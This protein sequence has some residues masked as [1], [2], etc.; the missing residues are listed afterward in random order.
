LPIRTIK[1]KVKGMQ[2]KEKSRATLLLL[3]LMLVGAGVC[4]G[5]TGGDGEFD[6]A[7]NVS[8]NDL[9]KA[10]VRIVLSQ[11]KDASPTVT[12]TGVFLKDVEGNVHL[13][14]CFNGVLMLV[15]QPDPIEKLN[16]S[17]YDSDNNLLLEQADLRIKSYD[18]KRDLISI[19][20]STFKYNGPA[21]AF[22]NDL[23][24]EVRK[25]PAQFRIL[26][27][28]EGNEKLNWEYIFKHQSNTNL[29]DYLTLTRK[30]EAYRPIIPSVEVQVV[31]G[32]ANH[33]MFGVAGGP[34]AVESN[35][36]GK[37]FG[38]VIGGWKTQTWVVPI[39]LSE[40]TLDAQLDD[41]QLA[42]IQKQIDQLQQ[43]DRA[44]LI[45]HYL[46]GTRY[47]DPLFS[48]KGIVVD[49][50]RPFDVIISALSTAS[51]VRE[52]QTKYIYTA[53]N[54]VN[55]QQDT[56]FGKDKLKELKKGDKADKYGD[57]YNTAS[58]NLILGKYHL[59]EYRRN[60]LRTKKAGKL[61]GDLEIVEEYC[62]QLQ[63][64]YNE[65]ETVHLIPQEAKAQKK[66]NLDLTAE[67]TAFFNT[68]RNEVDGKE[69]YELGE[70]AKASQDLKAARYFY[71][72]ALSYQS[73]YEWKALV[74]LAE[75]D[76]VLELKV[77]K[78]YGAISRSK[79]DSALR[80][81]NSVNAL[82]DR[83]SIAEKIAELNVTFEELKKHADEQYK[84]E[85]GGVAISLYKEALRYYPSDA[86]LRTQVQLLDKSDGESRHEKLTT[87]ADRYFDTKDYENAKLRYQEL[88]GMNPNIP[89]ATNRISQINKILED[90]KKQEFTTRAA[91]QFQED[92]L[93]RLKARTGLR[94]LP[95]CKIVYEVTDTSFTMITTYGM[96]YGSLTS[97]PEIAQNYDNFAPG[98][99]TYAG[100]ENFLK[101]Y[102]ESMAES[103]GEMGGKL[104]ASTCS[105]TI[106]GHVDAIKFEED[107]EY[108]EKLFVD[109]ERMLVHSVD[110]IDSVITFAEATKKV[111]ANRG[112]AYLRAY[113]AKQ[114][115]APLMKGLNEDEIEVLVL[116]E[117]LSYAEE[118][119]KVLVRLTVG[120]R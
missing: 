88:L 120:V 24:P 119:R 29:D 2:I 96:V 108:D 55:S 87:L 25:T 9:K 11:K 23:V 102:S 62:R 114:V 56:Y 93:Q 64:I 91:A 12:Q 15:S 3:M 14:T 76:E 109:L 69:A 6:N 51:A 1:N 105:M 100:A 57:H 113:R 45:D 4:V 67:F 43:G 32:T 36:S 65:N 117:K 103:L 37:P 50:D 27:Y 101:M 79:P 94:A 70:R 30:E 5:N 8:L 104:D 82:L 60:G 98:E 85:S 47:A 26:G 75:I 95:N 81:L 118:Y 58:F 106:E 111:F 97:A 59:L 21:V 33:D 61:R 74:R 42:T 63:G 99:V 112:L 19:D 89:Q 44:G 31:Q 107:L 22:Y 72:L 16:I 78:G 54:V 20:L 17:I 49:P 90:E 80:V 7:E 115:L 83:D 68:V 18:L 48:R 35:D 52:D 38:I 53:A 92:F 73:C 77:V 46:K 116:H 40:F 41:E 71:C 13:I 66:Y 28:G 110:S 34:I 86:Y 84:L 10:T 39:V